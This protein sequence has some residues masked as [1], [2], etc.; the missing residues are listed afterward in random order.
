VKKTLL[1]VVVAGLLFGSTLLAAAQQTAQQTEP[2]A[3]L[4]LTQQGVIPW[5]MFPSV[6]SMD[7]RTAAIQCV[8]DA[9]TYEIVNGP[10][11]GIV[12]WWSLRSASNGEGLVYT[13]E[14][15]AFYGH[16]TSGDRTDGEP[17]RYLKVEGTPWGCGDQGFWIKMVQVLGN[18]NQIATT[19][20]QVVLPPE[21]WKLCVS[22]PIPPQKPQK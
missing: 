2:N 1:I 13:Q 7:L 14:M 21:R 16:L 17:S 4:A 15:G 5:S 9:P 10:P 19:F 6:F 20:F 18:P 3:P 11:N 8:G 12:R 22:T